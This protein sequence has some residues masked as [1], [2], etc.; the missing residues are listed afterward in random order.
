MTTNTLTGVALE[1]Q[2]EADEADFDTLFLTHYDGIYRLLF[3]IVGS[4]EEAEDLA[5]E[6]FLRLYHHRFPPG[7]EHNVRA[8]LYRVATN[9][10]YNALRSRQRRQQRQE[11]ATRH[12]AAMSGYAPDPADVAERQD[13]RA[14]V[15]RVLMTLQPQ[16]AQLLLLR[17]AG[18]SYRELAAALNVAPGS[19]GTLLARAK[20]AFEIAYRDELSGS[21]RGENDE[22]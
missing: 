8:W 12:G 17:H 3:R 9:L 11:S 14:T 21:V 7:R 1:S 16:R 6:T 13:E 18:L 4:R 2:P 5:Q 15:R 20:A 10:A 19:V 22:V